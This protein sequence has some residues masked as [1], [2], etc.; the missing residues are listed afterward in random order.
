MSL[1]TSD[2]EELRGSRG[3]PTKPVAE[4]RERKNDYNRQYQKVR[5]EKAQKREKMMTKK[6]KEV[7][8]L[9]SAL[10]ENRKEKKK[11]RTEL[12]ERDEEIQE[13]MYEFEK[14]KRDFK[15]KERR[16]S[17]EEQKRS[18]VL[19]EKDEKVKEMERKIQEGKRKARKEEKE[20]RIEDYEH[21]KK[22]EDEKIEMKN[23]RMKIQREEKKMQV[24][25]DKIKKM[26]KQL[27]QERKERKEE[28]EQ[29]QIKEEEKEERKKEKYLKVDEALLQHSL[30]VTFVDEKEGSLE[31]L[32]LGAVIL[33][34]YY[35]LMGNGENSMSALE[36]TLKTFPFVS[37]ATFYRWRNYWLQAE[38]IFSSSRG[39]WER[40]WIL[41]DRNKRGR[42]IDYVRTNARGGHGSARLTLLSL[43]TWVNETLL[44]D[45][46]E[47][48]TVDRPFCESTIRTWLHRLDFRCRLTKRS[49]Y[50]DGHEEPDQVIIDSFK[51]LLFFYFF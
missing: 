9:K 31:S 38:E 1:P 5:R 8:G 26:E 47:R 11:R 28:Q 12:I 32:P 16:M 3:R 42:F 51:I 2:F 23:E 37:K 30:L 45:F 4:N 20:R 24:E 43:T 18:E 39:R 29:E 40:P 34:Q 7:E 25:M 19:Q 6:R 13:E 48:S 10:S 44:A 41:D 49:I 35:A 27:N 50:I 14:E 15:R 36:Q 33:L 17:N 21:K 22:M 46:T